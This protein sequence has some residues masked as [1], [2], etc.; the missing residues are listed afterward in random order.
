MFEQGFRFF[1]IALLL[2]F[3]GAIR[4]IF[5]LV[6]SFSDFFEKPFSCLKKTKKDSAA[7]G[8]SWASGQY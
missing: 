2:K 8:E 5:S 7:I 3:I 6:P 4:N 1:V